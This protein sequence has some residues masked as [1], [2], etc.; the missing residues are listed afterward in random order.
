MTK[1]K[2]KFASE[3]PQ[4]ELFSRLA[5]PGVLGRPNAPDLDIG[6]ELLGAIHQ[7]L[8]DARELGVSRDRVIDRMNTALPELRKPITKRQLDCWTAESKE[9]H[10]FPLRWLGAFCWATGSDAPLRAL[11]SA[12]GFDLVDARESAAKRL[13]ET[14]IE[15]AR[16]RREQGALAKTLGA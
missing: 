3:P 5:A 12:L 14:H 15:I 10:E 1:P 9:H 11:A 16:L 6:P 4:G 2:P 7:A 8:R 13:G